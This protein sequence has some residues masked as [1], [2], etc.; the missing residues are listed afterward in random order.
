MMMTASA[1]QLGTNDAFALSYRFKQV[2][3]E[4]Y[5]TNESRPRIGITTRI[6]L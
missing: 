5:M 3:T 4:K 6:E 2:R 1:L